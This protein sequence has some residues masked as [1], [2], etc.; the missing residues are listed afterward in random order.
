MAVGGVSR[1]RRAGTGSCGQSV[2]ELGSRTMVSEAP[3]S[4]DGE[5]RRLNRGSWCGRA[6]SGLGR[7]NVV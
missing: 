5:E 1:L 2:G 3:L 6:A 4:P 7:G